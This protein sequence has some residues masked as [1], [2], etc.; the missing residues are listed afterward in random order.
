ME[1]ST[2]DAIDR[3]ILYQLQQDARKP[4]TEI[5]AD[6]NVSDNTVRNRIQSLEDEDVIEGYQVNVEYDEAGVQHYYLFICTVSVKRRE[7]MAR[8][9]Q[10]HSGV[11]EVLTL[12]TATHNV[13]V[14][15]AKDEKD[16]ITDLAYDIEEIGMTIER[17]HLIRE[18]DRVPFDKSRFEKNH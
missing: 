9:I 5:A 4:V 2:L 10:S 8:K 17:E 1:L 6:L 16:D 13:L 7:E 11:T 12:M 3:A 18:H 15:A 14:F